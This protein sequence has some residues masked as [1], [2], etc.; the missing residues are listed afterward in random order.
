MCS[1]FT[2]PRIQ[3][4][5]CFH[6]YHFLSECCRFFSESNYFFTPSSSLMSTLGALL[7]LA[8]SWWT[9]STLRRSAC[10]M[11]GCRFTGEKTWSW[12]SGWV[13]WRTCDFFCFFF[14]RLFEQ[15]SDT[16]A[17]WICRSLSEELRLLIWLNAGRDCTVVMQLGWRNV[18]LQWPRELNTLFSVA[19][20][21]VCYPSCGS[22]EFLLVFWLFVAYVSF[23][24]FL[25]CFLALQYIKLSAPPLYPEHFHPISCAWIQGSLTSTTLY[26]S[27]RQHPAFHALKI[28]VPQCNLASA[29]LSAQIETSWAAD[30]SNIQ[31]KKN[32]LLLWQNWGFISHSHYSF[33]LSQANWADY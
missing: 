11:K 14:I 32:D 15:S 31:R 12:A 17:H 4:S 29:A 23:C 6:E 10:W 7:W 22:S 3:D 30:V 21:H 8:A 16:D 25:M 19:W 33:G 2:K 1:T 27:A 13:G 24:F 18:I 28:P 26:V 9:G 5:V 20:R